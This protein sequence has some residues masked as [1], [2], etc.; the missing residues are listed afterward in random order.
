MDDVPTS[1]ELLALVKQ[2][3]GGD[4][5]AVP[6]LREFFDAKAPELWAEW[7]DLARIVES[8][9]IDTIGGN[10]RMVVEALLPQGGRNEDRAGRA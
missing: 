3:E 6:A 7:G 5:A 10:N 4:R 8:K 1:D 9:W 2:A